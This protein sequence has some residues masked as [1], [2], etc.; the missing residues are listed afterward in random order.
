MSDWIGLVWLV[1]G[2]FPA[3]MP[4]STGAGRVETQPPLS[5]IA[6]ALALVAVLLLSKRAGKRQ[7]E[8]L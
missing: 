3:W 4:V 8:R 1:L 6:G 7:A 2:L 5:L